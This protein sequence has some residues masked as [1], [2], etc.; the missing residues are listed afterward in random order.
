M[1]KVTTEEMREKFMALSQNR[2]DELA[3]IYAPAG[4][5]S[6]D[7]GAQWQAIIEDAPSNR[8]YLENALGLGHDAPPVEEDEAVVAEPE[9]EEEE[10]VREPPEPVPSRFGRR[11]DEEIANVL[12]P[13]KGG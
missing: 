1:T 8:A 5:A 4:A 7:R 2:A 6:L 13:R 9:A 11:T 3:E 10:R 12:Y